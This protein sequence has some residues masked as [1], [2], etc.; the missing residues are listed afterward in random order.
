[1]AYQ[2]YYDGLCGMYA[3]ANAFMECG[4]KDGEEVFH[5][6][7]SVLAQKRWPK[8]VWEG[9]KFGDMKRMIS[10]CCEELAIE[11]LRVRYPF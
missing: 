8:T 5:T 6:A 10:G 7:C 4:V 2:G 1:M 3:I 9:T 11:G